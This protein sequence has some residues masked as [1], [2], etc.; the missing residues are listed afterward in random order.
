[1]A[2]LVDSESGQTPLDPDE[3]E[4]LLIPVVSRESLNA[5]EA[6]NIAS[7]LRWL[8]GRRG[9][10]VDATLSEVYLSELHRR[11]F[12]Q[13]WRWAG[14][15]RR[16]DKNIGVPWSEVPTQLR[17]LLDDAHE[18]VGSSMDPDEAAVRFGHRLVSVHPFVNGNGR[19][20]RLASDQLA[21]ALGRPVFAWGGAATSALP[22]RERRQVYLA[23][24][25]A[26]DGGDI[27]PLVAFARG[28]S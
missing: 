4:G 11:M 5:V 28:G 9:L 19:H 27:D 8:A 16:S 14:E 12:G 13:V 26:A 10:N 7:A 23:A 1:V 20:S 25:R 17:A 22:T 24:L 6:E 15:F 3:A 21:L 2:S 18:W